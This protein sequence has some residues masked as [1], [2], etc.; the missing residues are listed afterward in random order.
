M[1]I[2]GATHKLYI[3]LTALYLKDEPD[4]NCSYIL[5]SVISETLH[6]SGSPYEFLPCNANCSFIPFQMYVKL[7]RTLFTI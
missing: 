1:R 5:K 7:V 2:M 3:M 4:D 6:N